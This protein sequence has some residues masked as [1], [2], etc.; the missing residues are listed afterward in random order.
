MAALG[1]K[2]T[3]GSLP[4][5]THVAIAGWHQAQ[6][7]EDPWVSLHLVQPRKPEADSRA[8]FRNVGG[9]WTWSMLSRNRLPGWLLKSRIEGIALSFVK[10][11][12]I[13]VM[14]D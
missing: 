8:L 7:A 6:D 14:N 1:C 5:L 9:S 2:P 10:M 13:R 3:P 11:G 4:G 12:L